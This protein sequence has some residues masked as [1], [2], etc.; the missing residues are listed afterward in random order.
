MM[1]LRDVNR[2]NKKLLKRISIYSKYTQV[3]NRARGMRIRSET[4]KAQGI[5][6]T[7]KKRRNKDKIFRPKWVFIDT[8]HSLW[9]ARK[10]EALI[11]KS[12]KEKRI[13]AMGLMSRNQKLAYQIITGSIKSQNVIDFL[14]EYS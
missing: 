9:M 14:D 10:K 7:R 1:I 5:F 4:T 2:E 6:R 3:K 11:L 8:I 13:N 12:R